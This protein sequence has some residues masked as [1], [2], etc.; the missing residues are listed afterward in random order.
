MRGAQDDARRLAGLE[1][2]LPTGCAEAPTVAGLEAAK[3]EF[4]HRRRKVVAA[5]SRKLEKPRGH[6]GADRVAADVLSPRIAAAVA[7]EPR[8]G[9]YRAHFQPITDHIS[10]PV[11]PT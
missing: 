10:R 8:H 7:K 2:F 4:R 9:I 1:S 3:A 6:D 5:G 11:P